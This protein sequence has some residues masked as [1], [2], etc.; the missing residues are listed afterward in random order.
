MSGR[1][2]VFIAFITGG[3]LVFLTNMSFGQARI[4]WSS[5]IGISE[6]SQPGAVAS[7]GQPSLLLGNFL[8]LKGAGTSP[9]SNLVGA[10]T[11]FAY[12]KWGAGVFVNQTSIGDV[13]D[14]R[15]SPTIAY[16]INF[17]KGKLALGSRIELGQTSI[18]S[19][20]EGAQHFDD[21]LIGQE[22]S[23]WHMD[24]SAGLFYWKENMK[25][26]I[27]VTDLL[28]D[29]KVNGI[30]KAVTRSAEWSFLMNYGVP[31][32]NEYTLTLISENRWVPN[33]VR[34]H[35][36]AVQFSD[37]GRWL[38]GPMLRSTLEYGAIVGVHLKGYMKQL[39]D[40]PYVGYLISVHPNLGGTFQQVVI[41][42]KFNVRPKA[43]RV[44]N[45]KASPVDPV[46]LQ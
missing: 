15:I 10:Q 45:K 7:S 22:Q 2:K 21:P 34:V 37:N 5:A 3:V 13:L 43:K 18:E 19:D 28:N 6:L 39:K 29:Y 9:V 36:F 38:I 20:V 32:Q 44:K 40:D 8:T 30:D 26:G 46:Y 12:G 11:E 4:A 27:A 23:Y 17:G 24:L 1:N 35:E 42:W 16:R 31:L 25:I 41:N 14:M 33:Q